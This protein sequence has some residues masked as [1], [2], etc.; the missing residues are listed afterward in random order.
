[1]RQG[2]KRA[3]ICGAVAVGLA[4]LFTPALSSA[5]VAGGLA[6]AAAPAPGWRIVFTYRNPPGHI[7]GFAGIVATGTRDAWAVGDVQRPET[8]AIVPLAEHWTGTSWQ[9]SQ[10]PRG[11]GAGELDVVAASSRTNVWAFGR[12]GD[13]NVDALRWN[14][15]NWSLAHRFSGFVSVTGA[16]VLSPGDVW[17][18]SDDGGTWH[19]TSGHWNRLRL[20][21]S[22]DIASPVTPAD[23]W[24]AGTRMLADGELVPIVA[25][26]NGSAWQLRKTPPFPHHDLDPRISSSINAIQATSDHDVWVVG[27]AE[28]L[29]ANGPQTAAPIAIQ[30]TGST[31]QSRQ[32]RIAGDLESFTEDGQGGA[33]VT[34]AG[35]GASVP[36]ALLHFARGAWACVAVPTVRGKVTSMDSFARVPGTTSVWSAGA[37]VFGG[38]PSTDGIILRF[39]VE[40]SAGSPP[41]VY[42]ANSG[43][44]TVTPISTATNQAGKP[45]KVG[46]NPKVIA[47][48]PGGKTAYVGSAA[49]GLT[50]N[51]VTPVTTATNTPG[52]PIS[53]GFVIPYAIAITPDGKTAYVVGDSSAEFSG[54]TPITTATNTPGQVIDTGGVTPGAIAITPDQRTAYVANYGSGTVTPITT[55]TNTAGTP[56][57]VGQYPYAIAITPDGKTA[58]VVNYGSDTVT[59]IATATNT[60]G[61]PIS[62]GHQPAAIAITPD[63]KTAYV[64]NAGLGTVTPI[65]TATNKPGRPI[66]VLGGR[67]SA[68]VITPDGK[69]AYV[70]D[71]GSS[72]VTPITT[73][74]NRAGNPIAVGLTPVAIAITP[75]GQTAYVVNFGS[76]TVTP[77]ATATNKPGKPIRVGQG[78]WAIA[79]TP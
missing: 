61:P 67:P 66:P 11:L 17:L 63:G 68:I 39:D 78:P 73:A 36:C 74:T 29:P 54:V 4:G 14:G 60:A 57:S 69:K 37:L 28:T 43:T 7:S 70:A 75:H 49:T 41:T 9:P 79:V 35:F 48:T 45:I 3:A 13:N 62:V 55:A 16:A 26:W 51:S 33:W 47:I 46:P 30:W 42:V 77:I 34:A 23:I 20:A 58:Y 8:P 53:F 50:M 22:L 18:F 12:F 65:T 21:F 27:G 31:W 40:S 2:F 24:A 15:R 38:L 56:I 1:M 6:Q 44:D 59:P 64:V 72:S 10:L 5:S 19:L 52:T 32:P 71:S 25:R 76:G